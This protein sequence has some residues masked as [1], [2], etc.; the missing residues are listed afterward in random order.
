MEKGNFVAKKATSGDVD[1]IEDDLYCKRLENRIKKLLEELKSLSKMKEED[2][3]GFAE[4]VIVSQQRLLGNN[5]VPFTK[6]DLL[7]IYSKLY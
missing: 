7:T 5:Y 3:K 6:E 1:S 4:S 2:I